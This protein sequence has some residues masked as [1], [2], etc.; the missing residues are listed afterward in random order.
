MYEFQTHYDVIIIGGG[1][2]GLY[3][4][5]QLSKHTHASILILESKGRLGG[6]IK[7]LVRDEHLIETGAAR[8]AASHPKVFELAETLN[9]PRTQ[10]TLLR[11]KT[12]SQST[13]NTLSHILKYKNRNETLLELLKKTKNISHKDINAFLKDWG[14]SG[15]IAL[16]QS[17]EFKMKNYTEPH[18]KLSCG[19]SEIIKRLAHH[20]EKQPNVHI[21]LG[22]PCT[23]LSQSRGLFRVHTQKHTFT[24]HKIF[25]SIHSISS[26]QNTLQKIITKLENTVVPNN[27]IRLFQFSPNES[28]RETFQDKEP[29][30]PKEP[31]QIYE[32][33]E[34]AKKLMEKYVAGSLQQ[35]HKMI[36]SFYWKKGAWFW[37]TRV[38]VKTIAPYS[39]QPLPS[40][41]FIGDT[42][43]RNQAWMQGALETSD[44]ALTLA[45]H[46]PLYKHI[47]P[48]DEN[49]KNQKKLKRKIP[50]TALV[51]SRKNIQLPKNHVIFEN[52]VYDLTN[53]IQNHPGGNIIQIGL[54]KD[55]TKLF[56]SIPHSTF[57]RALLEK[58]RI[59]T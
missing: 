20:L 43:S 35:K 41:H 47:I 24:S 21:L 37:K 55:I 46:I 8:I 56:H 26:T 51:S 28:T 45:S 14:Y 34:K 54:Q 32:D 33:G 25:S 59:D 30:E 17:S 42:F 10:F 57:A 53:F 31:K 5:Y 19:L 23:S 6:R 29:K 48:D 40:L 44:S 38:N 15:N 12:K 4:A 11:E 16:L 7:S 36:E 3:T 2:S 27:Y 49:Q 13:L 18:F 22:H 9:I 39:L 58:Y 50:H 52:A 1:I